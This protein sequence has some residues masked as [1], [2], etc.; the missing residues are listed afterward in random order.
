MEDIKSIMRDVRDNKEAIR[1]I[2]RPFT[3]QNIIDENK[4]AISVLQDKVGQIGNDVAALFI[5]P[6]GLASGYTGTLQ[7]GPVPRRLFTRP[8]R[9]ACNR[10]ASREKSGRRERGAAGLPAAGRCP[11]PRRTGRPRQPPGSRPPSHI[12]WLRGGAVRATITE[13]RK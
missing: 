10:Q 7:D 5:L 8:G 2:S 3:N 6:P 11:G 9:P 12:A 1:K 4:Q 13:R